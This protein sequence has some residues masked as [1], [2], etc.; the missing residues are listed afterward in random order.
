[1]A[2]KLTGWFLPLP[3]L[4]WAAL[5][6][7]RRTFRVLAIGLA[8]AIVLLFLLIPPWWTEPVAGVSRFLRSNLTRGKTRPIPVQFL[9]TVYQTPNESLPWYNTIV[10]TVMVT[11]VGFLLLALAGIVGV[12]RRWRTEPIGLLILAHWILLMALR[13]MPRTPGHDGVRLF[14]PAFGVLALLAGLGAK[15]VVDRF[16]RRARLVVG[17]AMVEGVASVLLM[18]PVPLS[19]FSPVVGGL[20]GAARLGMEPTYYWDGLTDEAR[21][22]L[23][24]NTGPG[25]TIEFATFPTSWLYLREIGELPRVRSRLDPGI[26]AWFVIQNRPGAWLEEDRLRVER[27]T[28]AYVVTKFGVPL[29]WVLPYGLAR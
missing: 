5:F 9:G 13:A 11:P 26:P 23:R 16:G 12:L 10:W 18:M 29:V 21:S 8:L 25:R 7:E 3:F 15:Q 24:A 20:P 14:L 22:W 19:Y 17:A 4:A 28:P 6:R 1:M 2:T 27:S